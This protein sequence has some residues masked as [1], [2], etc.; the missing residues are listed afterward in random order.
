MK[1]QIDIPV[2][3]NIDID[4]IIIK[5]RLLDEIQHTLTILTGLRAFDL[6]AD[7]THETDNQYCI[8]KE[9]VITLDFKEL[10]EKIDKV[11]N[12]E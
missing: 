8:D 3:V 11:L 7:S 1:K 9:D 2:T 5:S 4:G 12:N 10:N 6:Y